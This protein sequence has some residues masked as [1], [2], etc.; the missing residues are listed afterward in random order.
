MP[1]KYCQ[2]IKPSEY[3]EAFFPDQLLDRKHFLYRHVRVW[4]PEA[5]HPRYY[6]TARPLCKWHDDYDCVVIDGWVKSPR[7]CYSGDRVHA[8]IAK[9]YKCKI[10]SELGQNC[11][12]FCGYDKAVI[13]KS[14]DYIKMLWKKTGYDTTSL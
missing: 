9:R 7:H 13:A 4:F 14:N 2:L 10:N 8:L 6:P 12:S 1:E 5:M 11:S 3:P